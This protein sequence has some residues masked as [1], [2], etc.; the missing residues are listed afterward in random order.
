MIRDQRYKY[1]HFSALP[2]LFFDLHK[3]PGEFTNQAENP[4]YQSLV[5]SYAQKML[6]WK[7]NHCDRGLSETMLGDGGAV[8]R[9]A[10]L[11]R[12]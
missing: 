11:Y 9:R 4:E 5:L 12:Q 3:D 8:T 7:M 2:P 6:S 1:V 10:P